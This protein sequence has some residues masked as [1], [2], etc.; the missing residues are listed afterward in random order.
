MVISA[1]L[2][3]ITLNGNRPNAAIKR[4]KVAEWIKNKNKHKIHIYT[5]LQG[6]H[7]RAKDT[8]D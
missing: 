3:I 4:H 5:A 8:T 6:T 1:Y 2:S 7:F